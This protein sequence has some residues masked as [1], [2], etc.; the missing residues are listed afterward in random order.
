MTCTVSLKV[1]GYLLLACKVFYNA[2]AYRHIFAG[3]EKN[4]ARNEET[5]FHEAVLAQLADFRE[6]EPVLVLPE[7]SWCSER[8]HKRARVRTRTGHGHCVV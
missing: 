6:I 4:D 7:K 3:I 2:W 1:F 8:S 5:K